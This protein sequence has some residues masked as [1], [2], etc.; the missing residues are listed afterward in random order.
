[1]ND[2]LIATDSPLT[3]G[4]RDILTALAD[5]GVRRI[6]EDQGVLPT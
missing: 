1:M 4:Q 2:R 6:E 3:S 5:T